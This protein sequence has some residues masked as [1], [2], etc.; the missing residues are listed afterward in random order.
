[1]NDADIKRQRAMNAYLGKFKERVMNN[2]IRDLIDKGCLR[3]GFGT[4]AVSLGSLEERVME[5]VGNQKFCSMCGAQS[6]F[7]EED[8]CDDCENKFN[9]ALESMEDKAVQD[10]EL[11]GSGAVEWVNGMP[12]VGTV[13]EGYTTDAAGTWGWLS[14][15]ILKNTSVGEAACYVEDKILRFVDQFRPIKPP[16]EKSIDWMVDIMMDVDDYREAA[17]MFYIAGS[18]KQE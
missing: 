1:M 18:R 16:K 10:H 9:M 6:L 13:C 11:D 7:G 12:Q 14:V 2:H 15:E 5:V 4:E 8:T 17:E 3:S